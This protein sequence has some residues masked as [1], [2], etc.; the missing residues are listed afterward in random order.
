MKRFWQ[1]IVP[2]SLTLTLSGCSSFLGQFH[3]Q[4]MSSR[5]QL[6]RQLQ[7][8][9]VFNNNLGSNY[10]A[11]NRSGSNIIKNTP[12]QQARAMREYRRYD[13][14]DLEQAQQ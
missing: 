7:T 8:Q 9:I 4:K 2:I 3:T 12:T 6:C 5:Q 11:P 1:I 14:E 10:T 13:C